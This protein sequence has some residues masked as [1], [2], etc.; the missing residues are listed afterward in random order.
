MRRSGF[1]HALLGGLFLA[2]I[3]PGLIGTGPRALGQ[4]LTWSGSSSTNWNFAD[5]NWNQNGIIGSPA[6]FNN[7]AAV[8]F[9]DTAIPGTTNITVSNF[10][11]QPAGVTFNN[12]ALAYSFSGGAIASTASVTLN[13]TAGVVFYSANTY[14]G[15]TYIENAEPLA[16]GRRRQP[17]HGRFD[18]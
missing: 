4:P 5:P 1:C 10:T 13:G 9:D 7:G 6:S 8:T 3:V 15:G 2:L 11:V 17:G 12:N 14:T 18:G 16:T